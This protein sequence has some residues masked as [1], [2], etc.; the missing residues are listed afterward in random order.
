MAADA[1]RH[2]LFGLLALQVGLIDQAQLVAAFHAW[3]RDKARP[4]AD[5][6]QALGHLNVEQRGL[7]EALAAQHLKKHG[8]DAEKSLAAVGVGASVRRSLAAI[9][10]PQINSTLVGLVFGPDGDDDPERTASYSVGAPTATASDTAS[11]ALTPGAAW[12]RSSWRSTRSCTARWRSSRSSTTTP[13]N[14]AAAPGSWP[15]RRSPAGWNIPGIVPVYSLGADADGRPFY[16]MRFIRGDTLKE[17]AN[18]FHADESLG[19]DPGRR[20]LELRKLLRQFVNVCNT[21][22]YAH[23]RGVL[24]R[25]IK[26]A[27]VIVGKYGETLVVDWG[28]AKA[29]G[30]I[31]PRVESGERTLIPSSGSGS[32]ETLPG[33]AMG[34]PAYMSPEQADGDLE[35]LG[36]GSDV[37]SLG[38]TLYYL[39]TGTA[40]G[41][42]GNRRGAPR[43]AGGRFPRRRVGATRRSTR[44]W[45]RSASRRWRAEP[46]DRYASPR[47]LSE[48]VERWMA[49]EPVSAW[50]EPMA[51]PR[52]PVGESEPDEGD[53]GGGGDRGRGDRVVGRPGGADEGQRALWTRRTR[54]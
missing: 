48:D 51:Q 32:A 13:T 37:Y 18:R 3:T 2:F 47:A 33:R 7:V 23:S 42:G 43:R 46:E 50:R 20:S 52:P 35:R 21:I 4:L 54:P 30:R 41:G 12:A 5:H 53:R 22:D 17:A 26:P 45:R 39:L 14:P 27:N 28:L 10:D 31:G 36:A 34:T 1:D 49:D 9:G 11:S 24:H 44:R 15:R 40:G 38:A 6:L 19:H 29:V 16:A 25:D 8:G